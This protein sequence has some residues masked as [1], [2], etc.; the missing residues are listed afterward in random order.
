M[1]EVYCKRLVIVLGGN[2]WLP[3]SGSLEQMVALK[4]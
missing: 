4:N 3:V 2:K 1:N